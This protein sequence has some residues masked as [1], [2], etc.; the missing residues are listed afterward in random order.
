MSETAMDDSINALRAHLERHGPMCVLTGAGISTESGIPDYRDGEGQWK[1]PPPMSHQAFM[2]SESARKRYWARSLVGFSVLGTAQPGIAHEALARLEREGLVQGIITQN[3]DR[4][5][6][7][8]GSRN[9]IDLH[10]RAD[11][12]RCMACRWLLKRTVYH[13]WL[14]ARNPNWTTLEAEVA[15]D[16]DADLDA[17]D[18]SDVDIPPCPRCGHAIMK[19][20]VVYFGDN[21]PR[22]RLARAMSW[23]DASGGLWVIGSS[24]M[25]F[26]GF[27]FARQAHRAGKPVLCL[28]RGH[29]RADELFTLKVEAPIGKAM[30]ALTGGA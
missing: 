3:V 10:G 7:K 25:V 19:P 2:K 30:A 14:A 26:S 9:V 17:D 20:D 12:V 1:R 18:F 27:R 16:G 8:A 15:P 22:D 29:T 4:L 24:L 11:V 5:H 21:V 6:Q 23:L 13:E 28:N